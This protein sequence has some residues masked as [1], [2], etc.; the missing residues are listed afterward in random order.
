[1]DK[2]TDKWTGL[3]VCDERPGS[4]LREIQGLWACG[5]QRIHHLRLAILSS[6]QLKPHLMRWLHCLLLVKGDE[7]LGSLVSQ[8]GWRAEGGTLSSS[9]TVSRWK[10]GRPRG[11][12][13]ETHQ[14]PESSLPIRNP[15][16]SGSTGISWVLGRWAGKAV[17]RAQP[18]VCLPMHWGASCWQMFTHFPN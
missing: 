13:K 1:M 15:E 9:L 7:G 6:A 16:Q 2:H 14:P 11:V 12:I 5:P 8:A 17:G 10:P 18:A 3:S 4:L